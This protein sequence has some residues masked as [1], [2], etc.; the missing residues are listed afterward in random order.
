M[1]AGA[2]LVMTSDS[3]FIICFPLGVAS[4]PRSLSGRSTSPFD[5][6]AF[7]AARVLAMASASAADASTKYSTPLLS[8]LHNNDML[9][10]KLIYCLQL[11]H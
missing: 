6:R 11:T 10:I 2:E 1:P 9:I 3:S 8:L 7:A 5:W 4:A